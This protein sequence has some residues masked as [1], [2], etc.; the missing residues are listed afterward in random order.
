MDLSKYRNK[1][2][3]SEE[4]RAVSP[5]IGVILMVA[6]TVILAA[7]IAAFVLDMGDDLG[8]EAQAGAQMSFDEGDG[9]MSIELTSEGNADE[10]ELRGD[11]YWD[12]STSNASVSKS[13]YISLNGAGDT[14][15][16]ECGN[17]N[18][19][20]SKNYTLTNSSSDSG[21]VTFVASNDGGD[22][23]TNVGSQDWDCNP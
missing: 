20:S 2:I 16:L 8:S 17:Y 15:T 13:E 22:T 11:Y 12:D 18:E 6:I 3:G 5:V 21:T 23:W 4:E 10:Y 14:V 19:Y 7:V 1:L 9:K